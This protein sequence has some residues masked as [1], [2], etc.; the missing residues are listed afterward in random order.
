MRLNIIK[1]IDEAVGLGAVRNGTLKKPSKE[2]GTLHR[3]KTWTSWSR[4]YL[5]FWKRWKRQW[6]TS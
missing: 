5:E 4:I 2:P 1:V 6:T 3:P